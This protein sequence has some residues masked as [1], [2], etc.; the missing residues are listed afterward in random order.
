MF[1]VILLS[2]KRSQF[3]LSFAICSI[4]SWFVWSVRTFFEGFGLVRTCS[5]AFRCIQMHLE[6]C[7]CI[8]TRSEHFGKFGPKNV[9]FSKCSYVFRSFRS[10]SDLF[11]S[12]RTCSDAFGCIQMHLEAF[13]CI[14]SDESD[15]FGKFWFR[16]GLSLV[17]A[18][19]S[20]LFSSN[21]AQGCPRKVK[22]S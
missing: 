16:S 3:L 20:A 18:W 8:G 17:F 9:T 15:T 19:V 11:G 14:Q 5:D 21:V 13:E 10:C 1:G 2:N 7:G 22:F 12:V 4:R 6:A